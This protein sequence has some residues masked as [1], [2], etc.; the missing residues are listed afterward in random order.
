M[1]RYV[2]VLDN[3][4]K[5]VG[6]K[7]QSNGGHFDF[8]SNRDFRQKKNEI[9]YASQNMPFWALS[10]SKGSRWDRI[11][12]PVFEPKIMNMHDKP[13]LYAL[14]PLFS[15]SA[16]R[17]GAPY[18]FKKLNSLSARHSTV[19]VVTQLLFSPLLRE[20]KKSIIAGPKSARGVSMFD[21]NSAVKFLMERYVVSTTREYKDLTSVF[22]LTITNTAELKFVDNDL[23]DEKG[24]VI[25]V[26][27][28]YGAPVYYKKLVKGK[29]TEEKN[30]LE[31]VS[32]S[33]LDKYG[34][35]TEF[36]KTYEEF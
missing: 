36:N 30:G 11:F 15:E 28:E 18:I 19:K 32:S 24:S 23:I 33:Y 31:L 22:G 12:K 10:L 25:E 9:R 2:E 21:F 13:Y 27:N 34:W 26:V 6:L 16:I 3:K 4:S 1:E 20:C 17:G 8:A 14:D 35:P 29:I 5:L 7:K